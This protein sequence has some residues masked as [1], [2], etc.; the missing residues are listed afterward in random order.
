MMRSLIPNLLQVLS[1]VLVIATGTS[2][3]AFADH[4]GSHGEHCIAVDEVSTEHQ[5]LTSDTDTEHPENGEKACVQHSCIAVFNS[6]FIAG[7]LLSV[8][9]AENSNGHHSLTPFV[10]VVNLYRPPIA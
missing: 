8:A 5:H 4:G 2:G 10:R 1:L 3:V 6:R 9:L 7:G